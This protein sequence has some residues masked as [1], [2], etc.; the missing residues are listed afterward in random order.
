MASAVSALLLAEW[1]WLQ[2]SQIGADC[3]ETGVCVFS[4]LIICGAKG[5]RG[6]QKRIWP[7]PASERAEPSSEM[8]EKTLLLQNSVHSVRAKSRRWRLC[9]GAAPRIFMFV[10]SAG[11]ADMGRHV[12]LIT[13]WLEPNARGGYVCFACRRLRRVR[14]CGKMRGLHFY[15][16]FAGRM[17][18][19]LIH[20]AYMRRRRRFDSLC[21]VK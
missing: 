4:S 20:L 5:R 17:R 2:A 8:P 16:R 18:L 9:V 19:F 21:V 10:I 12:V 3:F 7:L 11:A 13:S 6:T 15:D 1:W 14:E